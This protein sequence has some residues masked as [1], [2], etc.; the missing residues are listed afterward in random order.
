MAGRRGNEMGVKSSGSMQI[1]SIWSIL[2]AAPTTKLSS[3]NSSKA[4]SSR[5]DSIKIG[6]FDQ[7]RKHGEDHSKEN[8]CPLVKVKGIIKG[9]VPYDFPRKVL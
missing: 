5:C 2:G 8:Q 3:H 4:A 6:S 1:G 9:S 7:V